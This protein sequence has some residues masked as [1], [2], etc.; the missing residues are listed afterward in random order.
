MHE[1]LEE[2]QMT[3]KKPITGNLKVYFSIFSLLFIV[4]IDSISVHAT[5]LII[6]SILSIYAAGRNYIRLIKIPTYFLIPSIVIIAFFIPGNK[7]Q[8]TLPISPTME[9]VEIAIKTL[10]RSYASLSILSFMILTTSIPELFAALKRLKLPDFIIEI[11]LL[12]YRVIQVLM[13]ELDRLN[14]SASSRLGYSSKK[15]FIRTSSLLA[16][17]LFMKSLERLEKINTAMEARCYS[18]RMP[19]R[20]ERSKGY[21]ICFAIILALLTSL[22]FKNI[23]IE[24]I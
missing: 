13:D 18:G 11:S 4:I 16:Y 9:G 19:V 3:S 10:L 21:G 17:S 1:T 7:I 2:I 24:N 8:T 15:A 14:R 23:L 20:S 12:I 6:F 22:L 5:A